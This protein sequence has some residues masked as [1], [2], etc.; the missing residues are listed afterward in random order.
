MGNKIGDEIENETVETSGT[1]IENPYGGSAKAGGAESPESIDKSSTET[2]L[3]L[4]SETEIL[5]GQVEKLKSDYLYLKAEFDN[6]RRNAIKERAE[7]LKFGSE[8]I[9]TEILNVFDNFE[10]ALSTKVSAESLDNFVKGIEMTAKDIKGLLS[11]FSVTEVP[12]EGAPFDPSIHEA[13]ASEESE[14]LAAGHILRVYKKAFKLHDKLIRP[15]QVIV[16]KAK[17]S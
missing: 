17:S 1:G 5:L 16:A 9:W 13:L 8:R 3:E 11:K 2:K 12:C 7:L 15:A 4:K 6:Y 14:T 10:R